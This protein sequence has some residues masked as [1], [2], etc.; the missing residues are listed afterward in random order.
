MPF[1]IPIRTT[2]TY[3]NHAESEVETLS[4]RVGHLGEVQIFLKNLRGRPSPSS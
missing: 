4:G 3:L 2:V 1:L